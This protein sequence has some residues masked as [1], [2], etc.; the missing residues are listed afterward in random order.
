ME[1]GGCLTAYNSVFAV[2]FVHPNAF[3]TSQTGETLK[4]NLIP[5]QHKKELLNNNEAHKLINA[6]NTLIFTNYFF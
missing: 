2:R 3:C 1:K 4:E 5:Y 6:C